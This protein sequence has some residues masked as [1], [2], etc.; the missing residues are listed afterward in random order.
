M[1]GI[2][3]DGRLIDGDFF[4]IRRDELLQLLLDNWKQSL[5]QSKPVFI[6]GIW[7]QSAG[8]GV[9]PGNAG[10]YRD[11]GWSKSLQ[12]FKLFDHAQARRRR[13]FPKHVV[14][15]ALVVCRRPPS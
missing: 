11:T 12:S 10:F 3:T 7:N 14:F 2:A 15:S 13:D 8:H 5:S 9:W 4:T 6:M 1:V